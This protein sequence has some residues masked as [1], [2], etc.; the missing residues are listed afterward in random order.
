M[1]FR[2]ILAISG[3]PGLYKY[4]APGNKGIIV[5]SLA[6]GRRFNASSN[7]Q[8]S[9]LA[10]IAIF[11]EDE[12]KPLNEVYTQIFAF[13][14]GQAIALT[15][16]SDAEKLKQFL[17]EAMPDYDRDRVRVSDIKKLVSW[18]N[19]LV[20]AGMSDFSIEEPQDEQEG[21]EEQAAE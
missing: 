1:K 20:G 15:A 19:I 3:Q 7:S 10:E 4:V 9:A 6:D 16:K 5:E 8:V 12:D 21:S 2:D 17:A 18:F 14:N 11:T 13:T